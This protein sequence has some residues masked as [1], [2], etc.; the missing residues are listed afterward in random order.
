MTSESMPFP[1][2]A[3]ASSE[4]D[5]AVLIGRFQPF[6]NAHLALL[7]RALNLAPRVFVVLGSAFQVRSPRNP[8]L[9]QERSAWIRGAVSEQNRERLAF[10][11]VRDYYDEPRWRAYIVKGITAELT[12]TAAPRVTLVGH[13]KDLSSLYLDGFEGWHLTRVPAQGSLNATALRERYFGLSESQPAEPAHSFAWLDDLVPTSTR[14]AL[15]RFAATNDYS[16]V[17][18]E[19]QSLKEYQA[20]WAATPYPV[21]FVTVDAVVTC[22]GHVLL[23]RRG[24]APAQ[25]ELALPGGFLEQGDT[26]QQSALRELREETG[27]VLGPRGVP[28]ALAAKAPFDHPARSQRGRTIT[29]AFHFDLGDRPLP[30]VHASDDAAGIQWVEVSRLRDLEDQFCE[31]HFHILDTFLDLGLD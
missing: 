7:E 17:R 26:T 25:G 31:D 28:Y 18:S 10:M 3:R 8:W 14:E 29:H 6:H 20:A 1:P 4:F 30:E 12:A 23:I 22:S 5:A 9:W 27:L 19:W 24:H 11:P 2:H 13:F 16:R 21:V 15:V